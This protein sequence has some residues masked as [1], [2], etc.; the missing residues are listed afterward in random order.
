MIDEDAWSVLEM[1]PT[2]RP[3]LAVRRIAPTSGHELFLGLRFPSRHP[4]LI[5]E[6]PQDFWPYD[7]TLPV[8][9]A[10]AAT[11][12]EAGGVV[13]ATIELQDPALKDVFT[14]L[15]ND[16]ALHVAATSS[17]TAGVTALIERLE[18]WRRLMEPDSGGGMTLAERRGLFGELRVLQLAVQAGV[19]P[20]TTLR[21]WVGPLDA[22]QDFQH[23]SLAIEVKATSTKQPQA[24]KISSERQLDSTGVPSLALIH[25]SLDERKQGEGVSLPSL[26]A[27][28]RD[29]LTAGLEGQFDALLMAYGWLPGSDVRYASPVYSERSVSAYNVAASFPRLVEAD[30]P[31]GVG[32]VT[33]M[34]QIGALA[35]FEF[36]LNE[37]FQIMGVDK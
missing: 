15:A 17:H 6:V 33:Y 4:Q 12:D 32:D 37:V 28:V 2:S 14:A 31:A 23:P 36:E 11:V 24:I 7:V 9:R 22:H 27:E 19:P 25:V 29:S 20:S 5:V 1:Q 21:A 3:G 35:E 10:L 30:C 26:I 34:I 16:V 18:R 13:K 8:F